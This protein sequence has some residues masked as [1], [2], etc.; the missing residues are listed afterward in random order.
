MKC[1]FRIEMLYGCGVIDSSKFNFFVCWEI[2]V[3][4]QTTLR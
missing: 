2:T 1:D 3:D 4:V